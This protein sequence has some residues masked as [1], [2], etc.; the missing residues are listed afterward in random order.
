M[1]LKIFHSICIFQKKRPDPSQALDIDSKILLN[2]E[3]TNIA[4]NPNAQLNESDKAVV[5]C[6]DNSSYIADHV[7]F[8]ASL[9]VLK[10][11]HQS[12]FTPRLPKRKIEAIET[13]GF[14]IFAKIFLEF[15]EPFWPMNISEWAAYSILWREDDINAL[16]G[17]DRE[18]LLALYQFIRVDYHPNVIC[19]LVAGRG[20]ELYEALSDEKIF[21]DTMWILQRILNKKINYPLNFRRTQWLNN[22]NFLGAYSYY[23]L[24]AEAKGIMPID[25]SSSLFNA[26][27][28]P[29]ILFA[30]EH[31]DDMYPGFVYSGLSSGF[32]TGQKLVDLY[33][34]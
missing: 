15:E 3:V 18:W 25:L 7:I 17:S 30:G 32:K 13:V 21:E 4:W 28:K 10:E 5:K 16:I 31:T 9:G 14:G 29:I 2:K 8:T 26:Q 19:G 27:G 1:F 11:R 12:L 23:T 22:R 6:A 24:A 33:R 34:K 20:I